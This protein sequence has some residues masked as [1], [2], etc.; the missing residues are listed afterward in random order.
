MGL[1]ADG[2]WKAPTALERASERARGVPGI[3]GLV[4]V[5]PEPVYCVG[6]CV[7]FTAIVRAMNTPK[8][9]GKER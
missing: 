3:V 2:R 9:L 8:R 6:W 1:A 4:P 5:L 7:Q